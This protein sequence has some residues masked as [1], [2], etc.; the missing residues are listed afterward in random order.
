MAVTWVAAVAL[1]NPTAPL[2]DEA[3]SVSP[4]LTFFLV[5]AVVYFILNLFAT[6][7]IVIRLLL[8]RHSVIAAFG[9]SCALAEHALHI[10]SIMLESAAISL[11][12]AL[13]VIT[14]LPLQTEYAALLVQV[15]TPGQVLI[16]VC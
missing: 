9:R 4:G 8:H 3:E 5:T 7:N 1:L 15:I 6:S 10:S 11:P 13:L 12:L 2:N 16:K 14:G